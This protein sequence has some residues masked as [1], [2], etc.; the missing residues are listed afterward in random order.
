MG[1]GLGPG[2]GCAPDRGWRFASGLVVGFARDSAVGSVLG[3]GR[4][5]AGLVAVR[6]VRRLRAGGWG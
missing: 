4:V 5:A 1:S 6:P 3:V 2:G